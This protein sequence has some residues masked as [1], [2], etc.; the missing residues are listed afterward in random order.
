MKYVTVVLLT[1]LTIV[2]LVFGQTHW[3]SQIS[4]TTATENTETKK[5]HTKSKEEQKTSVSFDHVQ[6]T[7]LKNALEKAIEDHDQANILIS[8]STALGDQESGLGITISQELQKSFKENVAVSYIGFE[9]TSTELIEENLISDYQET[10]P[11]ILILE[12]MT[13]AD[14]SGGYASVMA[15]LENISTI[16]QELKNQNEDLYVILMPPHP[17][18]NATNY[19]KQVEAA[20]EYA[21]ENNLTYIDH[22]QSWPTDDTELKEYLI[23]GSSAPNE[24]GIELWSKEVLKLFGI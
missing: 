3:S 7:E 1:L 24:K 17:I 5:E 13:L 20:K 11:D 6:D 15:N 14:N 12:N 18:P 19:P 8:G 22:W 16:I 21:A 2:V 10:K 23:E 9:G 4:Q